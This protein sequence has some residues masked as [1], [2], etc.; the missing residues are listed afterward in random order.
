MNKAFANEHKQV[1]E[2]G[3]GALITMTVGYF[4][5]FIQF[6]HSRTIRYRDDTTSIHLSLYGR[7][8]VLWLHFFLLYSLATE[9]SSP[10]MHLKWY[11]RNIYGKISLTPLTTVAFVL[12]FTI[13]RMVL[14]PSC[15]L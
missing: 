9:L 8:A 13:V 3:F 5:G 4:V 11:F 7:S 15:C 10:L 12:L 14:C 6:W 2:T 1:E